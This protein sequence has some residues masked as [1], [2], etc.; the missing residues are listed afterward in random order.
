MRPGQPQEVFGAKLQGGGDLAAPF[1]RLWQAGS[2][3]GFSRCRPPLSPRQ[4]QN[5]TRRLAPPH[6]TPPDSLTFCPGLPLSAILAPQPP[7]WQQANACCGTARRRLTS[8]RG[9]GQAPRPPIPCTPSACCPVHG[10]GALEL[11]NKTVGHIGELPNQGTYPTCP[12]AWSGSA[13]PAE[14]LPRARAVDAYLCRGCR[15]DCQSVLPE[16]PQRESSTA[17]MNAVVPD[18]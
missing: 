10:H 4:H 6:L 17:L 5:G 11:A 13:W 8:R 3:A 9:P 14:S 1:R 7:K 12:T 18:R 15:T 2:P 16:P